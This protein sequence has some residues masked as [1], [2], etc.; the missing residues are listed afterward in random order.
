MAKY[1]LKRLGLMLITFFIIM[2]ICFVLVR[3]L[4]N[5]IPPGMGD[6]AAAVKAMRE[7]WGYNKPILTQYGIFL[8]NIFTKWD[9]GFCTT[10][11]PYL[12]PV[13]GYLA[14][15]LPATVAVNT[16]TMLIGVPFGIVF[17]MY[18]A[19]KKNRWQDQVISVIVMLFISVPN[20]VYAF[21]VQYFLGFKLGWFPIVVKS[22]TDFF[23]MKMLY[24]MALPIMALSFGI[25]ARFMRFTRAELTETLTS[26][27][28]LLARAKGLTIG[29]ATFRHAFRNSLVPILPMIIGEFM[30]ILGGSMII[31][32]I[33][34]IPG[35]GNVYVQSIILRDYS[36][37]MAISMFYLIIGLV[38]GLLVDL[39][40]GI[41]DPR[42]RMGGGKTNESN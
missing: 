17:G 30:G 29:Q 27:Y 3:M 11:G 39:S 14:N 42:I 38:S 19:L 12:K 36:V 40:Y 9:W 35:I 6:F 1:I 4:P 41:V 34:A 31:E 16:Y 24:T 13:T 33:F 8:R 2:T 37:F 23:S 7:A 22:G 15:K 18:A 21:I 5:Q 28:M 20:Y 32:S 25:I 10:I 26:E